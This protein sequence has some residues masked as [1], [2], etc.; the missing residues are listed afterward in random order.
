MNM[1]RF[2][3]LLAGLL[4]AFSTFAAE[5]WTGTWATAPEYTGKGDMPQN[6]TLTGN[7]LRQVIHVSLG[8]EE[9]RLKLTNEFSDEEVEIRSVYIADAGDG[10]KINPKTVKYLKFDGKENVTIAPHGAVYSDAVKYDLK[11]LQLLSITINYGERT[12]E[13]ATSHR[14][15]RTTSYIMDGMSKPK[16]DFVASEKLEHW[17]NISALEVMTDGDECIAVIGNSITDGRGTTNNLQNR[18][19]DVCAEAL[20]GK[21]GVLNLGIGGNSV[22]HGGLSE[23]AVKRFDRDIMGQNG[24]TGIVIY[25]GINDIGGSRNVEKTTADLIEAYT[26]F[27]DKARAKGLK[28]Y[29]ATISQLGNTNYWSY[30]HEAARQAVN[31]W[32]RT[33]GKFDG[34]IDFDAVLADPANPLRMNP[35]YQFDW[36]HP[37]PAGY[38]AMGEAAAKV[39]YPEMVGKTNP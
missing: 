20:G 18:W 34:V 12:P 32:I 33:S 23:P 9:L 26:S 21:V 13:H 7:S 6:M 16:K 11:P 30:F 29:G 28:V 25:E 36:L 17:Y 5:K 38:K 31:E 8:G 3:L 35:D 19:T 37:N 39:M 14:G 15:S 10:E 1:K 27:I 22:L 4:L 2:G 24:L